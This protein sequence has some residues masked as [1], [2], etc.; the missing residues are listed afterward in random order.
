MVYL[1]DTTKFKWDKVPAPGHDLVKKQIQGVPLQQSDIRA[2]PS[3]AARL[4]FPTSVSPVRPANRY[5]HAGYTPLYTHLA[6]K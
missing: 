4:I 5:A 3:C 2:R 6:H 1:L